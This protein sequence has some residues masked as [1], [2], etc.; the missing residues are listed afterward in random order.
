MNGF[1]SAIYITSQQ[2]QVNGTKKQLC[3]ALQD[4]RMRNVAPHAWSV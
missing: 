4:E 1:V 2:K 3:A